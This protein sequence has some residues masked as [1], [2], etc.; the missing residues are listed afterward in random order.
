MLLMTQ[1]AVRPSVAR[2]YPFHVF[3]LFFSPPLLILPS[4]ILAKHSKIEN[5]KL[6]KEKTQAKPEKTF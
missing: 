4:E 6:K 3:S 1:L 2:H 5:Q